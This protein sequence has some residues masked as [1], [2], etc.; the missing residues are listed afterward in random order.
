[1]SIEPNAQAHLRRDLGER[2]Q[3]IDKQN[4]IDLY[5]E[6]LSSGYSVREILSATNHA[7]SNSKRDNSETVA[8][9]RSGSENAATASLPRSGWRARR[10]QIH[11]APATRI[12]PKGAEFRGSGHPQ[13][14]K[15][16]VPVPQ[17]PQAAEYPP[18]DEPG[19]DDREQLP[20]GVLSES[21]LDIAGPEDAPI[22]AGSKIAIRS[23]GEGRFR[24]GMF[25]GNAKRAVFA[26]FCTVTIA[27]ASI[28]GFALLHGRRHAE[29]A[30]VAIQPDISNRADAPALPGSAAPAPSGSAASPEAPR[31]AATQTAKAVPSPGTA[32]THPDQTRKPGQGR[33]RA[34]GR[35]RLGNLRRRI[36]RLPRDTARQRDVAGGAA[37]DSRA[38]R[39]SA[40]AGRQLYGRR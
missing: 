15:S 7:R 18:H 36:G 17:G 30:T 25:P 13:A 35:G 5:Y 11:S 40:G 9:S 2:L 24:P 20:A 39:R 8:S 29:P 10:R 31:I 28:A 21:A 23:N 22:S 38:D 37:L 16:D 1:M 19:T 12:L 33:V 3:N 4:A 27:C 34:S 14:A 26:A 32:Q 6:L